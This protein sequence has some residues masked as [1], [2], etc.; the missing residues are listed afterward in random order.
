MA[1]DYF[2]VFFACVL[3]VKAGMDGVFRCTGFVS[4]VACHIVYGR[5]I[6]QVSRPTRAR[7]GSYMICS[8]RSFPV[9]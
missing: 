1:S 6:H 4:S 7:V 2:L 8:P 5:N 9:F 3:F